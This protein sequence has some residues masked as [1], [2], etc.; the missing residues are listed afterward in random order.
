MVHSSVEDVVTSDFGD[1]SENHLV[2]HEEQLLRTVDEL[3][4]NETKGQRLVA[5]QYR[6]V[7]KAG[8]HFDGRGCASIYRSGRKAGVC[9]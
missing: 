4:G 6:G 7:R 3:L 2:G 5:G 1:A 8:G 9:L